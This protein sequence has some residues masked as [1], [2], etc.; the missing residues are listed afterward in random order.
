MPPAPIPSNERTRLASLISCNVLDTPPEEGFDSL[1]R[2]ASNLCHAPIA[3]ISL[4]DEDRQW[5]KSHVGIDATQTPRDT[6]FCGY[7]ILSEG[8]LVITDAL[9]DERTYDNPLVSGPPGIRFYAGV[10]LIVEGGM[11]LGTL[12]VIDVVPREPTDEMMD[13]LKALAL[14]AASQLEL[15]RAATRLEQARRAAEDA[16]QAKSAFLANM[17]HEV[18]TPLT[19]IVGYADL[20]RTGESPPSETAPAVDAIA[21]NASHLLQVVNDILDVSKIE[22]GMMDVERRP[23]DV[24]SVLADLVRLAEPKASKKSLLFELNFLTATP[25]LVETDALR[26]RQILLNLAY[27]A[28]K[29]TDTGGVSIDMSADATSQTLTIDIR[30]TGPGMTP[31]QVKTISRFEAFRQADNSTTR[32]FGGTGLGLRIANTLATLLDG[33]LAVKSVVGEGSTFSVTLKNLNAPA[34][35]DWRS[36]VEAERVLVASQERRAIATVGAPDALTPSNSLLGLRILLAEDSPDSQ[37]LITFHLRRAGADVVTADDGN[38]VF[39]KASTSMSNDESEFDVIL[40]DVEMPGIDG[41]E[42]TKRLRD[43]GYNRP[44]IILSAHALSDSQNQG[45]RAG[46]D[47]YLTKPINPARLIDACSRWARQGRAASTP[48]LGKPRVL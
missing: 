40:M 13:H 6:A 18:R 29:F 48:I 36:P 3:L 11:P 33:S 46:A 20:L 37:R 5:F 34:K 31:E 19:S 28:I 12:C 41:Y 4:V 42:A 23:V 38:E 25:V 10:P 16:N 35:D 22:A 7:A 43:R 17:S 44:I 9:Q 14:Q 8:P 39:S 1:T 15:R 21:R 24:V 27:N 2:L 45:Y 30:D 47:D 32:R 26:L